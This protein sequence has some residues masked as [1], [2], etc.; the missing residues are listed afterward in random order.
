MI[1]WSV[2]KEKVNGK[3]IRASKD[4][5]STKLRTQQTWRKRTWMCWC[6]GHCPLL[7]PGLLF[8]SLGFE[9]LY[10]ILWLRSQQYFQ[11]LF[12]ELCLTWML[13]EGTKQDGWP[14]FQFSFRRIYFSLFAKDIGFNYTVWEWWS[15]KV[16]NS[17]R[18]VYASKAVTAKA[19]I[20]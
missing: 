20:W 18:T 19:G 8:R 15:H 11:A 10:N 2:Y 1:M 12:V 5:S 4:W 3:A 6:L 14:C 16:L 9:S 17:W 13:P 7:V